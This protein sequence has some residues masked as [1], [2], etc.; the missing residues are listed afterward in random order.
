MGEANKCKDRV[1]KYLQGNILD[2]GVD[3]CPVVPW[4]ITIDLRRAI[5]GINLVGD[6]RNLYWFEDCVMD[7]VFSSHCLEDLPDPE[8]AL[9]EWIRVIKHRGHLILY[10]PD[11]KWYPNIGQPYANKGHFKDYLPEDIILIVNKIGGMKL[12]S[13]GEYGPPGGVYNYENRGKIEYSFQL[14]YQKL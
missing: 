12:I 13:S 2:L 10:M 3:D 8:Q 7:T 4:A 14:I 6:V 11:K 5:D 1:L 9:R